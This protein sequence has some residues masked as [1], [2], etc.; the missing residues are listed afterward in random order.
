[1]GQVQLLGGGSARGRGVS[2][3]GGVGQWGGGV[4]QPGGGVGQPGGRGGSAGGG[5]QPPGEGWVSQGEGW[6]SHGGG[7][8]QPWGGG[9]GQVQPGGWVSKENNIG[10]TCCMVG[11]MPLAFTQ[12]DFLVLSTFH[13]HVSQEHKLDICLTFKADI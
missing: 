8:G 2:H 10:S 5:G 13:F 7:V 3:G 6:V 9:V 4:G 1:M 11:S 12:E